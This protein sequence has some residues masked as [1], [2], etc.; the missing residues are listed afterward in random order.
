VHAAYREWCIAHAHPMIVLDPH[1]FPAATFGRSAKITI[2]LSPRRV[3]ATPWLSRLGFVTLANGVADLKR[4]DADIALTEIRCDGILV[5]AENVTAF[6]QA[7]EVLEI[8]F[9]PRLIAEVVT[10]SLQ[11]VFATSEAYTADRHWDWSRLIARVRE[12]HAA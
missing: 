5:T 7:P 6:T 1:A 10:T 2:D 3:T 12:L 8:C 11:R 4:D 9:V